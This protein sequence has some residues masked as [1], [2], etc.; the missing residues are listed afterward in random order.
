MRSLR[1]VRDGPR[2]LLD[3]CAVRAGVEEVDEVGLRAVHH[4][5]ETKAL[6]QHLLSQQDAGL[7]LFDFLLSGER[8]QLQ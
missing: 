2:A 1:V 7:A 6:Q 5:V 4:E 8:A 3:V